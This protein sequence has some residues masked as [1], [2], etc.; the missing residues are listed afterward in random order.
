MID[1]TCP[2]VAKVHAEARRFAADGLHDRARRP[3]RATRR[4]RAPSARRR[5]RWRSSRP[6]QDVARLRPPTP[7]TRR[8]PDADDAGGRR[9]RR[10]SSTRCASGSPRCARPAPTTSAT[11]PP[12]AS[13]RSGRSPPSPTWCSSPARRTR[14]TRGAWS[15]PASAPAPALPGRRR[16]GHRARLADGGGDDRHHRRR[17]RPACRGRAR[18]C[19]RSQGS[20]PCRSPSESTT[21][22]ICPVRPAQGGTAIMPVPLRQRLRVGTYLMRQ[23]LAAPQEVPAARRARAAVRVQPRLRRLRQDPAAGHSSSSGCRSSRRSAAI[24]ESGAPMVSIAGGEPLMHPEI[25]VIV[26]ELIK[27]KKFVFLCTNALLMQKKLDLFKPSPYFAWVVHIDGLRERHDES[28]CKDGVFDKAVDAIAG[29]AARLPG[30]H[31]HHLLQHRHAEDRPRRARL[32][33]RRAQV[34][35]MM[36]SPGLRLREGAGPGAL[37]RRGRRRGSCSA[38]RSRTGSGSAG[39]STTPRCSWTSSRARSTST[40]RRGASRRTRC[41]AGSGRAT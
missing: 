21:H 36:I 19:R 24:E 16:G 38:R 18:S 25:H 30:E 39:G 3:R 9:D 4:S 35:E 1:A 31:E 23:K 11:R 29:Q 15:R 40:A 27:R 7:A 20:A 32:P 28:V 33:Q 13:T 37:P 10:R 8:L 6:P 41:S 14:P 17:L 5:P 26:A 2:L 34:D 22:G 12:T